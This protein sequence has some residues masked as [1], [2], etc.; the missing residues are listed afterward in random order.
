MQNVFVLQ[1]QGT[2]DN[3]NAWENFGVF[4]TQQDLEK[5]LREINND[6]LDTDLQ[7]FRLFDNARIQVWELVDEN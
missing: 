3:E 6:Y 2:G 4:A 7:F 1:L 5:R